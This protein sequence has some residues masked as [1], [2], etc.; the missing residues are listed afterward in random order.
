MSMV[1]VLFQERNSH[2]HLWN[3]FLWTLEL[4]PQKI[5]WPVDSPS[6]EIHRERSMLILDQGQEQRIASGKWRKLDRGG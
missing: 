3:P 1:Y 6:Q 4:A 5:L 2:A